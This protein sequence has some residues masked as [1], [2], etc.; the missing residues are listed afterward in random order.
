MVEWAFSRRESELPALLAEHTLL[1]FR[2]TPAHLYRLVSRSRK[3]EMKA[4][5]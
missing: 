3:R 1:C 5:T 2:G 4:D